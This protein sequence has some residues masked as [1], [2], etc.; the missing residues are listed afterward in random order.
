VAITHTYCN[1]N[2]H[3]AV[4]F[5]AKDLQD[6]GRAWGGCGRCD[7]MARAPPCRW[8]TVIID[9]LGCPCCLGRWWVHWHLSSIAIESLGRRLEQQW[10]SVQQGSNIIVGVVGGRQARPEGVRLLW[11]CSGEE[12]TTRLVGYAAVRQ[13]GH[14]I[15]RTH[16]RYPGSIFIIY[17][18]KRELST[19]YVLPCDYIPTLSSVFDLNLFS[20]V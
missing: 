8:L 7:V 9:G 15:D 5:V 11:L 17:I 14:T 16:M 3:V 6:C 2:F 1:N 4:E 19:T 18:I 10:E 20:L 12:G 13:R